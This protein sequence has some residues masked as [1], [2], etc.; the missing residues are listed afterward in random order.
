[1]GS[2][3]TN[4]FLMRG[5]CEPPEYSGGLSTADALTPVGMEDDVHGIERE[6][7]LPL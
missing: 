5:H 3:L 1:M 4:V 2:K 6:G 7:T